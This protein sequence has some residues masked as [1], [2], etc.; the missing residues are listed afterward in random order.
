MDCV[1]T[2]ARRVILLFLSLST[3]ESHYRRSCMHLSRYRSLTTMLTSRHILELEVDQ[4]TAMR[5]T[6]LQV[7]HAD[8][9]P[10]FRH[11]RQP[12]SRN[13]EHRVLRPAVIALDQDAYKHHLIL[14]KL[15]LQR[16]VPDRL[17]H[18]RVVALAQEAADPM[19]PFVGGSFPFRRLAV[20]IVRVD[21]RAGDVGLHLVCGIVFWG[22]YVGG[23]AYVEAKAL[24]ASGAE[25]A[26]AAC[27]ESGGFQNVSIGASE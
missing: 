9:R 16:L 19:M 15:P 8:E 21:E 3:S 5:L 27:T 24:L 26:T 13:S 25:L 2:V 1:R 4:Q 6:S 11:I 17:C 18:R 10:P 22:W 7:Q 14:L 20:E 23:A 12:H